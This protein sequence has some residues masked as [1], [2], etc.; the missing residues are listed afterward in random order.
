M[1]LWFVVEEGI[2]LAV[3]WTWRRV[4]GFDLCVQV[5]RS[6]RVAWGLLRPCELEEGKIVHAGSQER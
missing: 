5:E 2:E 3:A 1:R 6:C 4:W